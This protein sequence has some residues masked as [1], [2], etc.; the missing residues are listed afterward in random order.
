MKFR[1]IMPV[2]ILLAVLAGAL[3]WEFWPGEEPMAAAP[4]KSEPPAS[5]KMASAPASPSSSAAMP[6]RIAMPT[7][8][9]ATPKP[10]S[11]EE[12]VSNQDAP[13]ETPNPGADDPNMTDLGEIE[14]TDGV[15]QTFT[16]NTGETCVITPSVF[17]TQNGIVQIALA[18]EIH[19]AN[20]DV[21]SAPKLTVLAGKT[22]R[23]SISGG[24][25]P[26]ANGTPHLQLGITLTPKLKP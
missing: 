14:F 5:V 2:C 15:P 20:N 18:T 3:A 1:R 16:L 12:S 9:V 6:T 17:T 13:S 25:A 21:I 8:P 10:G 22:A 24:G 7:A 11:S 26:N 23:L 4:E 19:G